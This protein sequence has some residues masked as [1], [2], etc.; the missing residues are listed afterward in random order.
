MKNISIP[1]GM[2]GFILPS[3]FSGK[4]RFYIW[5]I[6]FLLLLIPVQIK[7]QQSEL[8]TLN[9]KNVTLKQFVEAVQNQSGYSFLYKDNQVKVNRP[10]TVSANKQ[11]INVVLEQAFKGKGIS[12]KVQGKQILLFPTKEEQPVAAKKS[13]TV[14]GNVTTTTGEAIPG[15]SVKQLSATTGV[16]TD[17][18]GFYMITVPGGQTELEFRFMGYEPKIVKVGNQTTINVSLE[19]STSALEEV[20]VVGYGAQKKVTMTGSVASV[21][22]GSLKTPVANL[23]NAL[24]GKVAGIISVQSSGEPGYDN[25]TFTIRGISTFTGNTSPLVIVDGVQRDDVNSTYGGAY[26]NIDPEDIVSISLLKD[27]SATAVYGAK[28]ANGVMIITTKRGTVGKPKIS[29]KAET[30]FTTFTKVPSMLDGVGY[31]QLYNEARRN[32]GQ[33]EVYSR[34]DILKTQTGLDP[35]LYPNVDWI[36]TAYK[37]M[38]SVSNVNL[39]ISGGSE[40]VRYYLSASF[41]NQ[42]GQYNVKH[43][44]GFN[45]NLDYKRYDFRSNIDVNITK[46]T[47]LQMNLAAM[48]VDSRYPGVSAARIWYEAYAASPVAFPIRYPDGRWAGPPANAGVNPMDLLQNSGYSDTFRPALQSVFTL[49][50][51]LDFITKGL[52]AYIRFSFDSYSEFNNKRTGSVDLW[53]TNQRDANGELI[54]NKPIR[55]GSNELWYEHS[56]TGERVMY[57]EANIAYDHS[58]GDH[59]VSGMLL[60]NM[61]NRMVAT[62]GSAIGAI[63]YR[64]QAIAGRLSY[65]WKDRY[66]AEVNASYTGSENFAPNHRFG[67]FPAASLGW[68]ISNEPFFK[69]ATKYIDLLKLRASYGIVGNDNIGGTGDRFAYFTQYGSGNSYGFGPNGSTVGGIKETLLASES[70]TWEKSYKTNIGLEMMIGGKFNLTLDYYKERRK[71]ILI[72]RSSLPAMSGFGS[73][74]IYAN[75]GEMDNQGIDANIEYQ[76]SIAQ[77]VGLR[78]FGNA[79]YSKNKIVFKDEPQ[80]KYA[81]QKG[82]GTSFGEFYGYIAEGYFQSYE[83]IENSPKQ[84]RELAPGDIK[85]KDL[86]GDGVIDPNDQCYL[87]KSNFPS[88]SY[89]FGVNVNY[90]NF[91]LALFFQGVA[92]VSLMANGAFIDTGDGSWGANGVGIV[93]FAG[94]GANPTNIISKAL[95]RWTEDNP[96]ADAWYPR[97]TMGASTSDNNYVNS[98]HW[99]KNGN[100]LRLKQA[101]LGYT[102]ENK[103]LTA[104]GIDY[105]Y[106]YLSG[107]NLLT[108]SKF[109]L[110]DPELGSNGA[111]YPLSRMVTL[112]M[113]VAF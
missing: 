19:E 48:M 43:E 100:Y 87:G 26:N 91:D 97:M 99:L 15:A 62:A 95:D 4:R 57:T 17:L 83:E 89:G 79:T 11:S 70:L 64:N 106:F 2:K 30:G 61:R 50:Q 54:F 53:Y 56:D 42:G 69:G 67:F 45:P 37:D 55:E 16:I 86:N 21:N 63:P 75:M 29:I 52:S 92:D 108:F 81:Y 33:S 24:Q 35:Y 5:Q 1:K 107:Q 88:W 112:G 6:L 49:N 84:L 80:M 12:W 22:M 111:K 41:Y 93:P 109:K 104:K 20:V 98:T 28:G 18:D 73:A 60:Y 36:G 78:V 103:T 96:R 85:Y 27:A 90:H 102:L 13:H 77:K 105:L 32:S 47:L 34:G 113:R 72:Q 31:M 9:V 10:I 25:S 38:S 58:F 59:N 68:V 82:E 51:K 39:N 71:D 46:S 101:S 23:S 8:L 65:G 40:L 7:A 74:A 66:L 110:W 3:S 44:N 14:K 94:M 76:T